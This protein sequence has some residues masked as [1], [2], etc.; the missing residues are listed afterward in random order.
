MW[1]LKKELN[2]TIKH[3]QE[4][5]TRLKFVD[6]QNLKFFLVLFKNIL[7]IFATYA[8]YLQKYTKFSYY[9]PHKINVIFVKYLT[10]ISK[11]N[12]KIIINLMISYIIE[13]LH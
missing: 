12:A 5:Y 3:N 11:I 1:Y 8:Y 13:N 10:K 7:Y 4:N 2:K 9:S 6:H